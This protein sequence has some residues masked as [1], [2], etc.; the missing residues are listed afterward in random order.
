MPSPPG[1]EQASAVPKKSGTHH[2]EAPDD[3]VQAG[4]AAVYRRRR[5]VGK[6]GHLCAGNVGRV[7]DDEWE[8]LDG[9]QRRSDVIAADV[10]SVVDACPFG[11]DSG[12]AACRWITVDLHKTATREHGREQSDVPG[13]ATQF[14]YRPRRRDACDV[15]GPMRLHRRPRARAQDMAIEGDL[16]HPEIDAFVSPPSARDGSH[17]PLLPE[18]VA[19]AP[20]RPPAGRARL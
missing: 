13:T 10:D 1:L 7:G 3:H 19:S 18:C 14:E 16:E 12:Q 6:R 5:I 15:S 17:Q 8:L 20:R 2:V 9:P 11:V 4:L